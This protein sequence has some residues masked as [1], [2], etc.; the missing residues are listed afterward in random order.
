[1]LRSIAEGMLGCD[2]DIGRSDMTD[3]G[4]GIMTGSGW[5]ILGISAGEISASIL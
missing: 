4:R 2:I 5:G 1:L 3:S